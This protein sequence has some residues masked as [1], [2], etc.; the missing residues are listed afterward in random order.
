[1]DRRNPKEVSKRMRKK[2]VKGGTDLAR[3]KKWKAPYR[4]PWRQ[5]HRPLGEM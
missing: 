4:F 2:E 1:M 5:S 3:R